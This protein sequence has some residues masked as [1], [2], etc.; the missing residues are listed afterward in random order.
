MRNLLRLGDRQK[1]V[2]DEE[3]GLGGEGAWEGKGAYVIFRIREGVRERLWGIPW[4]IPYGRGVS[5]NE[6]RRG[7]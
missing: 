2:V 1:V 3:S 7:E 6:V 4:G 5:L